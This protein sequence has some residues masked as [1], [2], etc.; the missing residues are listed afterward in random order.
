MLKNGFAQFQSI[1]L[2]TSKPRSHVL[3]SQS[4]DGTS[5]D[6]QAIT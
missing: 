6:P 2:K 5:L 1:G 3:N 4:Q